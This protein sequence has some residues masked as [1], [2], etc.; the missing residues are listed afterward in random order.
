MLIKV[1][2]ITD[3]NEEADIYSTIIVNLG[4]IIK[5]ANQ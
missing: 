3:S 4:L 5:H 1:H 2:I